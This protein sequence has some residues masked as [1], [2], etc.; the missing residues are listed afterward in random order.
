MGKG[1]AG[2]KQTVGHA[3]IMENNQFHIQSN[4]VSKYLYHT[5]RQ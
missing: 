3:L 4:K 1:S 5:G 2:E